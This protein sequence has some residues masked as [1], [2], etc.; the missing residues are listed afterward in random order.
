MMNGIGEDHA[1]VSRMIDLGR[2]ARTFVSGIYSEHLEE[3]AFLYLQRVNL[4][5]ERHRS[6]AELEK[7]EQRIQAHVDALVSGH[8][9]ALEI[10]REYS[11]DRDSGILYGVTRIYC[12]CKRIDLLKD[13]VGGLDYGNS[14]R[15]NA[16]T[17]A[18]KH[19]LPAEWQPL[20][21]EM[22]LSEENGLIGMALE[23]ICY[24]RFD[25][26]REVM[27]MIHRPHDEIFGL[28]IRATGRLRLKKSRDFLRLLFKNDQEKDFINQEIC[29]ALL[30][31]NE[32]GLLTVPVDR[33]PRPPWV[34]LAMGLCG[35]ETHVSYLND[36]SQTESVC[37]ES[38]LAL[39]F[40]GYVS[41]VPVLM[42]CLDGGPYS[43]AASL[44]LHLMTGADLF[45]DVFIPDPIDEDTLFADEREK[46]RNGERL[47][48]PGKEPGI[49][50]HR[51]SHVGESWRAW[52]LLRKNGFEPDTAYRY[53]KKYS[54]YGVLKTI[55]WEHSPALL[56]QLAYEELVIR[57]DQDFGFDVTQPVK[58]QRNVIRGIR[59]WIGTRGFDE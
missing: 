23:V 56:R 13:V 45:E 27:G 6:W 55:E 47:Y 36:V 33:K 51:V 49:T 28:A 17:D 19:D 31:L 43:E 9:R 18:L 20:L 38:L 2:N 53:G 54:P 29:M 59:Q 25:M 4:L 11:D 14:D 35:N 37:N 26:E 21:E 10:C 41:S 22:L 8:E 48:P 1:L 32:K 50:I 44:A 57:H 24:R 58:D 5:N 7:T 52:W 3:S 34:Y 12:R 16:V 30:R 15:V 46:L 39:G 42:A 40:L